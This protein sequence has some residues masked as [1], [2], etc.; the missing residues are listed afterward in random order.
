MYCNVICNRAFRNYV[1]RAN[2][3]FKGLGDICGGLCDADKMLGLTK[4]KPK[5]PTTVYLS[6]YYIHRSLP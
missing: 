2:C 5:I 1:M 3:Y 6:T 4:H